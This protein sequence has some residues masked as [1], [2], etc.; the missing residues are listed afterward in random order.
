MGWTMTYSGEHFDLI[1]PQVEQ[2]KLVDIAHALSLECRFAGHTRYFYSVAQH[3]LLGAYKMRED[4]LSD[5]L[6]LLF[7]LH[8]ATETWYRDIPRPLK[9]LLPEYVEL[10]AKAEKV[11]W[12]AFCIEEPTE[13]EWAIVKH[14]DNMMLSNEIPKLMPNPEE[15]DTEIR[16]DGIEITYIHPNRVESLFVDVVLSLLLKVVQ[17]DE[18]TIHNFSA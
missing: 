3:S 10:E 5:R 7:M 15:F 16:D 17:D 11:V 2:V 12:E 18:H 6:Q 8:D 14:Y 4:G 13:D 9:A 1:N